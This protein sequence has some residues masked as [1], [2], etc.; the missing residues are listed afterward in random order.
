MKFRPAKNK[1]T[2]GLFWRIGHSIRRP[3]KPRTPSK[4]FSSRDKWEL[5]A[6]YLAAALLVLSVTSLATRAIA[7]NSQERSPALY[8]DIDVT[9][10]K[11][12]EKTIYLTFDDGPSSNTEMILDMLKKKDAKA[13]FFVTSQWKDE[14]FTAQMLKRMVQEG[15]TIGLHSYSHDFSAIYKSPEAY[16]AD[17]AKLNDMVIAA[18]GVK[19]Q[20]LRF[21]GGS[22]TINASK[23]TMKAIIEETTRRGYVYYDWDV[24]SGDDT[25]TVLPQEK[26]ANTILSGVKGRESA[27]VLC[28]DNATPKT[29]CGAV[30]LVIDTLSPQGYRF[31]ALTPLVEPVQLK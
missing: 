28:H 27:V 30:E 31:E 5:S 13:T 19:P 16:I 17:I 11:P 26:I 7:A 21:P 18:T 10:Q 14:E 8:A 20:I 23:S 9:P 6:I 15:H 25:A 29:T 1:P 24:V 2:R 22:R 12:P 4:R 3:P